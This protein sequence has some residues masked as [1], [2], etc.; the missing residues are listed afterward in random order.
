MSEALLRGA[1]SSAG[2]I[3]RGY[4][5]SGRGS[6]WPRQPWRA[7]G[8]SRTSALA[9]RRRAAAT[10]A[11]A[12]AAAAAVRPFQRRRAV[13]LGL[14]GSLAV[15]AAAARRSA[16]AEPDAEEAS[17]PEQY[18]AEALAA[19]WARRPWAV[20]LRCW[21]IAREAVPLM[22]RLLWDWHW[23]ALADRELCKA[24]AVSV[25][26]VL[27]MLGPAFIKAGQALSIRPDLLPDVA[28]KELQRLC[29][30][31][32][33]FGWVEAQAIL[34][35]E[36]GK[37]PEEVFLGVDVLAPLPVAAASL[38]QVYRWVRRSDGHVVAVKVQRPGM[39]KSVALDLFIV[40]RVAACGRWLLRMVSHSRVDHVELVDAW[41]AGTYG[42]LDYVEEAK[43]QE[44]FRTELLQRMRGRVYVPA[45]DHTL[46]SKRVLVSEWV[47]GPRLADCAP[48]VIRKLVPVGV[49]CFVAQLLDMG[50]FHAD[51][52]PGNL[53]VKDG[54]LVLLDFGLVAKIDGASMDAIA[55]SCVHLISA[56]WEAL[57]DDLIEIGFL[58]HGADR[59]QILPPVRSVLQQGV[60]AGGD[61][62]RRA[63][64]FQGISDDLN[65]IFYD[66]PFSVPAYFA[67][68]TR[69][70][71]VLEGIALV[72][73]P[74]FDIFWSAYPHALSRARSLLGTRRA[75]EL[76]TSAAAQAAQQLTAEERYRLWGGRAKF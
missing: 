70:L 18:D 42:E 55:S 33:P 29:D 66:L 19:Y 47:D 56:D 59:D 53:L 1:S 35:T 49:E 22:T 2:L 74:E 69:A 13:L 57:F 26:E 75:A 39:A 20:R 54:R 15:T 43:N 48:E 11:A 64:N 68:I 73:N 30:D 14:A 71:C 52:H 7:L 6:L 34:A 67:L 27:T 63:Q 17:L 10:T 44:Y 60:R 50:R 16:L 76:L 62:R 4:R 31:C 32:P 65:T 46:T 61:M 24:R 41:A 3:G 8:V 72:G 51:P 45:V 40:R 5:G 36:L 12:N 25:R 58:P 21:R 23:G 28:L 9:S 37:P 38:G